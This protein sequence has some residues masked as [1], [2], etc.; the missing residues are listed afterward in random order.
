MEGQK[1]QKLSVFLTCTQDSKGEI[2]ASYPEG[3]F[4]VSRGTTASRHGQSMEN[5]GGRGH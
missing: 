2:A 4:R 1:K 3:G 5:N